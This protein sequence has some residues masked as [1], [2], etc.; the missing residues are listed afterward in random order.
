MGKDSNG[1]KFLT[2]PAELFFK[3]FKQFGNPDM[4]IVDH[5][6]TPK[7]ITVDENGNKIYRGRRKG[8]STKL[9]TV[10]IFLTLLYITNS[11]KFVY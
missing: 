4:Q 1:N 6:V 9:L 3:E 7:M 11:K 2:T 10:K 5:T 8:P